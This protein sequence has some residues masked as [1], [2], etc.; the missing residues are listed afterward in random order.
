MFERFKKKKKLFFI[1]F[2]LLAVTGASSFLVYK[3]YFVPPKASIVK[4]IKLDLPHI[5]LHEEMVKFVFDTF[6]DL[7]L[8]IITFNNEV[9]SLDNEITRIEEI[10]SKYPEQKKIT[11]KEKKLG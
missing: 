3:M 11:E 10:A 1:V 5:K 4:Y 9:I 2:L 8:S 7:Y 6:P